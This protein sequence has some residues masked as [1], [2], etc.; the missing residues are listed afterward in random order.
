MMMHRVLVTDN[1][2]EEGLAGC[3]TNPG[4]RSWSTPSWPRIPGALA[5]GACGRRRHRDPIRHAN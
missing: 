4:S 5:A 1:L 2:A 3:V